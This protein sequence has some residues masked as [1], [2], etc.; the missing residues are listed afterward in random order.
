M[1][2]LTK[3]A[4]LAVALPISCRSVEVPTEME[5]LVAKSIFSKKLETAYPTPKLGDLHK[6]FTDLPDSCEVLL[7]VEGSS[8]NP[9]DRSAGGPFPEVMGS[10]MAGKVIAVE[11]TCKRLQVGDKVWADIGANAK[12][13]G[14]E[15]G[16][17]AQV[18]VALETQLGFM[19]KN[20][21]A[22]EAA[23]L[24]KVS[25]T[26]IK[27]LKWYGG[28]PYTATNGTVVVLG[29]SGG[30]GTS[31]IQ[32]AKALGA[33]KVI[34]TTSSANADYCKKLGADQVIDYHSQNWWEVLEDKSVDVIYDTVGQ[35]GTG[36]YAMQKIKS[37]GFFVTIAGGLPSK[38]RSDV[39]SGRF[40]NSDTN[41]DNVDLLDELKGYVEADKLRMPSI[42]SYDLKDVLSAFKESAAGHVVGK[43]GIT[44]PQASSITV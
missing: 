9:C 4:M 40:I 23:A 8:V 31:G 5:A 16:A 20:I 1:P 15:N 13:S 12:P 7:A 44:V 24:A 30:T 3:A 28:A 42:K 38:P 35:S 41:L 18:A 34:T 29:G 21:E 39:K 10:D 11:P 37:G 25:L 32:L 14:K 22:K 26:S 43:I 6:K 19:P 17:Y 36:D 33:S 27:A 2:S